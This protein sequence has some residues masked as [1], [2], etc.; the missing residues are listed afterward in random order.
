MRAFERVGDA[1]LALLAQEDLLGHHG[2]DVPAHGHHG[3][4]EIAQLVVV[5][6]G[7][8]AVERAGGDVTREA[9][10]LADRAAAAA[11]QDYGHQA[12]DQERG[13]DACHRQPDVVVD[14][15][16]RLA[17]IA[18]PAIG[19]G[20]DQGFDLVLD[21]MGAG[22]EDREIARL[23]AGPLDSAGCRA[24]FRFRDLQ[25]AGARTHLGPVGLFGGRCQ[26]GLERG[27]QRGT[28]RID[29]VDRALACGLLAVEVR[30]HV[31]EVA[32]RGARVAVG[33]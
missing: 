24:P 11:A 27:V 8:L 10:R 14:V 32:G 3:A 1:G 9:R 28:D 26:I 18:Q 7:R 17:P 23:V 29:A 15:V 6:A 4:D 33:D 16:L 20:A 25:L 13:S 19:D 21:R 5:G 2:R 22:V 12:G 31:G 30:P